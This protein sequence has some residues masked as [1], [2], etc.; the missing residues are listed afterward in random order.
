MSGTGTELGDKL[1]EQAMEQGSEV[2]LDEVT[3][4][5]RSA[6]GW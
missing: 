3:G 2:E 4:L 1:L 5:V 6:E